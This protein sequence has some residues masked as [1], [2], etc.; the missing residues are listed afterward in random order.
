[1]F[2]P[3]WT[4]G[5]PLL[6]KTFNDKI[7]DHDFACI[8]GEP[9][10]TP[11]P[12]VTPAQTP[13]TEEAKEVAVEETTTEEVKGTNHYSSIKICG[14]QNQILIS[15]FVEFRWIGLF[16]GIEFQSFY[17]YTVK[18]QKLK[19]SRG[20]KTCSKNQC[21]R[22]YWS[23]LSGITF[24][25][26]TKVD[27]VN[28]FNRVHCRVCATIQSTTCTWLLSVIKTVY[29]KKFLNCMICIPII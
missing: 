11:S 1:M 20:H 27:S 6:P 21:V 22:I 4:G 14:I 25:V 5:L 10:K 7:I 16:V 19:H 17:Q 12:D 23:H 13:V 9:E 18:P 24:W 29:R 28:L 15:Y 26:Q 8:L 2:V 3:G